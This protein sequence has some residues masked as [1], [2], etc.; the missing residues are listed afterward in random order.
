[1]V[2]GR[3][4]VSPHKNVAENSRYKPPRIYSVYHAIKARILLLQQFGLFTKRSREALADRRRVRIESFR[5]SIRVRCI[6]SAL[7]T[8]GN[9]AIYHYETSKYLRNI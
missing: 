9:A 1:M 4:C 2:R 7:P 3:V 8:S 6:T 5:V